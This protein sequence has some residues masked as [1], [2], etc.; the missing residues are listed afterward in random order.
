MD[1]IFHHASYVAMTL[2]EVQLSELGRCLVQA[3]MSCED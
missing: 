2:G 3:G 1:D